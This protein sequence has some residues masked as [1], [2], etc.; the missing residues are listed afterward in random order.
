MAA[1]III[2][3]TITNTITATTSTSSNT[4]TVTT[5]IT[6]IIICN[7]QGAGLPPQPTAYDE[8][9]FPGVR[10]HNPRGYTLYCIATPLRPCYVMADW[11]LCNRTHVLTL[12]YRHITAMLACCETSTSCVV[13]QL[14]GQ[15]DGVD[16]HTLEP[17]GQRVPP[18]LSGRLGGLGVPL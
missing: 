3:I 13:L 17:D 7:Y 1:S 2:I 16:H 6:I 9:F 8:V 14:A 12:L 10:P 11:I 15:P 18:C 5:T 4:A